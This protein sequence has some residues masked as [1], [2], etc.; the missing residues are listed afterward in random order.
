GTIAAANR[1]G[2]GVLFTILLPVKAEGTA[3]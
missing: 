3:A 1:P 2:G